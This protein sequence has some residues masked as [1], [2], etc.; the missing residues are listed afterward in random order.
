MTNPPGS[1]GGLA[2]RLTATALVA[3]R[4]LLVVL[5]GLLGGGRVA[6]GH[7]DWCRERH[8]RR[9]PLA[10]G[11]GTVLQHDTE[12]NLHSSFIFKPNIMRL[13]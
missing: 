3:R 8:A 12:D 6:A 10:A 1:L 11:A 13:V 4:V 7:A 2:P 9:S 5:G